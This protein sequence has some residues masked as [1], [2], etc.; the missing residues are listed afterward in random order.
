MELQ[1]KFVVQHKMYD[2]S[3]LKIV[4]VLR[5]DFKKWTRVGED[6]HYSPIL[7]VFS[8]CLVRRW[9]LSL[10]G[11]F[12]QTCNL[13]YFPGKPDS[14]GSR[15]MVSNIGMSSIGIS[16]EQ[17]L[18]HEDSSTE[19]IKYFQREYMSILLVFKSNFMDVSWINN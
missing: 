8:L 3:D 11:A 16:I 2:I 19:E 14:S 18:A 5:K 6:L 15:F 9:Y 17:L 1:F 7:K 4:D 10:C 12:T 13:L